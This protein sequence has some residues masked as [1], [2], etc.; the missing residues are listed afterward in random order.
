MLA[1]TL[2]PMI[3]ADATSRPA[4][5]FWNGA[6]AP[7]EITAWVESTG[8]DLPADLLDFWLHTGGGTVFESEELLAPFAG[9]AAAGILERNAW[10]HSKGM[11]DGFL[12]FHEGLWLSAVRSPEPRYVTLRLPQ[13]TVDAE[14][15]SFA[16]WYNG[17]LRAEYGERY[18]HGQVA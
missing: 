9:P 15:G 8:L 5:F 7:V 16:E 4:L 12:V 2:E 11:L 6:P 13:Y 18:A 3:L 14:F 17:T 10:H 1:P